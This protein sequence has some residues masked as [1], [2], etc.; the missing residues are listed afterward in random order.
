MPS[1]HPKASEAHD[2]SGSLET[3]KLNAA[4]REKWD[5]YY[6]GMELVPEDEITRAFNDE[7]VQHI[8]DLLPEGGRTLEAGSGGGWQS[9]ALARSGRFGVSVLDFSTEALSYTKRVFEREGLAAE[10]IH[11]DIESAGGADFDLVF[12]AGVLEHYTVPRQVALVRGMAAR[13]RRYVMVLVPNRHC[14][15]YWAW[16]LRKSSNGEW[17]WGKEVPASGLRDVFEESGLHF[18]GQAYLGSKWT[19]SFI[20]EL[21]ASDPALRELLLSLHRAPLVDPRQKAYLV[22]ALGSVR[23]E[24][25]PAHGWN[26]KMRDEA[27]SDVLAAALADALAALNSRAFE[28]QTT[29]AHIP[30]NEMLSVAQVDVSRKER[31]LALEERRS[32]LKVIDSIG[33]QTAALQTEQRDLTASF[34]RIQEQAASLQALNS[35][36]VLKAQ[37][38]TDTIQSLQAK[39]EGEQTRYGELAAI[40]ERQANR[41]SEVSEEG[42]RLRLEVERLGTEVQRSSAEARGL[43]LGKSGLQQR[44]SELE[45]DQ[46]RLATELDDARHAHAATQQSLAAIQSD[47]SQRELRESNLKQRHLELEADQ[48]RLAAELDD[49]RHAHAATQQSLAA[50][51]SQRHLELEAAQSKL[52]VELED[53]RQVH[54][55]AQASLAAV[56]SGLASERARSEMLAAD[57][58]GSSRL[59][60][61]AQDVVAGKDR[62]IAAEL[63][64][65]KEAQ[66]SYQKA[67]KGIIAAGTEFEATMHSLMD[68]LRG[69]RA[70]QV[71]VAIRKA[72]TLWTRQGVRGKLNSFKVLFELLSGSREPFAEHDVKFPNIWDYLSPACE[73]TQD[74]ALRNGLLDTTGKLD[75]VI[76]PVF[77][78][79]FRFQRPQQIAAQFAKAG[80]RVFWVS[81]SRF[82]RANSPRQFETIQLNENIYE[83]R[84]SGQP[85]QIY[86][87]TL[88]TA[89]AEELASSLLEL[90]R[91]AGMS[92]V[93]ILVQFPFWRQAALELRKHVNA[94]VVYDCMDDWRS[95][96]AEPRISEFSLNEERALAKECDVLVATSTELYE[97]Q[98]SESGRE[99]LRLRNGVD[100]EF[101]RNSKE[102]SLLA[103]TPKPIVGYY[104]AIADWVD[105]ELMSDLA[106]MRPQYSFVII[107]EVH[108]GDVSRLSRLPN[109][110]MLGEKSYH[111]IPSYLRLFDACLFPFKNNKLT[112]AVD[113]VK[114]YE[115][116]SQG[117]PVIATPIPEVLDHGDLV[118]F[119]GSAAEFASQLDRAL[120]ESGDLKAKRIAYSELNSWARRTDSLFTAIENT[121]PLVSIIAVSY[122]S[123]DYLAPFLD[124]VRRNTSYPRYE[125]L[126]VDN[127]STDGTQSVLEEYSK[128]FPQMRTLLSK[129]NLGFASGNNIGASQA[130]G[131]YLVL[132]NVDTVVPWGWL[133]RLIRPLLRDP[134][135]G[136]IAPVTN[137]SGNETRIQ[138]SYRTLSDMDRF[139]KERASAEFNRV[140]DLDMVPLM[141]AA[142]SRRIWDEVGELDE[143][144]GIGM[145]EDDDYCVR[146]RNAGYRIVTA[147]DCFIHHFGNGSFGKL[148]SEAAL[149]LFERN[150]LYFE[151]KWKRTW[152]KHKMRIGV[153]PLTQFSIIPVD[154]FLSSTESDAAQIPK[155]ALLRLHPA[156]TAVGQPVNP[157]PGGGSALVVEC[158][159]ATPGTMI[160]W[161]EE[162]LQTS[163]GHV[164]LLSGILPENFNR[165]AQGVPVSLI[166]N[167]GESESLIF[168]VDD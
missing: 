82:L 96:T 95:W 25:A 126:V 43:E 48:S 73:Q 139:A 111:L 154:E 30:G 112:K 162:F 90:Y 138:S 13:S 63:A 47:L 165:V 134:G 53:A 116:L 158:E 18:L 155:L 69:Q 14:Y 114:V 166:N 86:T 17:P 100:F 83:V 144:F 10:Y 34:A 121:Y 23:Q 118:Y 143:H 19:E 98:K 150:R 129:K 1:A 94:R 56:R 6:A 109:V 145:F 70:W 57:L 107:G 7:L 149:K 164:G 137:F 160:R 128:T 9:L 20:N 44:I 74:T 101:F 167:L 142:I 133:G 87:E 62:Q 61:D 156:R 64:R 80:H 119:A 76:L 12:N 24:S 78:F 105:V 3:A 39:L 120:K 123:R 27:G 77:D 115:Y 168:R 16:R 35:D 85:F 46:S 84:V 106:E 88:A 51:Q 2:H 131:D 159:N 147:E 54:A 148:P 125:L 31:E 32:L 38:S 110:Q 5:A 71:M 42:T 89:R 66:E 68:Q 97:R 141:C 161:G 33:A 127:D 22:A 72:Y 124:S 8:S 153:P 26:Y 41:L 157:Q 140:M 60:A 117:K 163:Y 29:R 92:E 11:S 50:I 146:I 79:E 135:I 75:I 113:P 122:N 67:R 93:A 40:F 152:S 99:V 151:S 28:L 81:P 130:K 36:L 103:A 104:G 52:S 59:L 132:L 4:E 102:N 136:M 37:R 55:V 21:T 65:S 45:A 49:A 108:S 91:A 58:E 15:W